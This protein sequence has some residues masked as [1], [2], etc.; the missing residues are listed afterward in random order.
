MDKIRLIIAHEVPIV[1]LGLSCLLNNEPDIECIASTGDAEELL[2]ILSKTTPAILII[3]SKMPVFTG[4]EIAQQVKMRFPDVKII[5]LDAGIS[6]NISTIVSEIGIEAY[7]NL[8]TDYGELLNTIYL[9]NRGGKI[10][11]CQDQYMSRKQDSSDVM[12]HK[13]GQR[14][15]QVFSLAACGLTNEDI[16]ALMKISRN[17]VGVHLNKAYEKLGIHSRSQAVVYAL[18]HNMIRLNDY[19]D[20]YW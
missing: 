15:L 19:G 18:S 14:E 8:R 1:R 17:T 7:L 12:I 11:H 16:A 13:L 10:S 5:L 6:D 3:G 4:F 9:V 2:G 20:E